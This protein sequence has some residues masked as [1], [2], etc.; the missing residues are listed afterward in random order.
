MG[1][2]SVF[3]RVSVTRIGMVRKAARDRRDNLINLI[4]GL[5]VKPFR[6]SR[7]S[8][9]SINFVISPL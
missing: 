2:E 5:I 7:L 4:S 6:F 3:K 9:P 1:I 8:H